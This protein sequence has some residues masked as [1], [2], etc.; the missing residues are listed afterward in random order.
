MLDPSDLPKCDLPRTNNATTVE[1]SMAK[2][3]KQWTQ[4]DLQLVFSDFSVLDGGLGAFQYVMCPSN[5]LLTAQ[6]ITASWRSQVKESLLGTT[7]VEQNTDV[8]Q[9]LS[10]TQLWALY[11]CLLFLHDSL[12]LLGE[13]MILKSCYSN[14]CTNFVW[15]KP[16]S[17]SQHWQ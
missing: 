16:A 1:S 12:R 10:L 3:R 4:Y 8:L 9:I 5:V 15:D 2:G 13:N 7:D 14:H 17:I 6:F 11:T